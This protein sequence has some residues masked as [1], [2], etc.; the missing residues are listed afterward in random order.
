MKQFK[1]KKYIVAAVV[2]MLAV[3]TYFGAEQA[4][5]ATQRIKS[6]EA[7]YFGE[8]L[9]VG[10]TIDKDDIDVFAT[11]TI[12]DGFDSYEDVEEVRSGFT[13]SPTTVKKEGENKVTV[14]YQGKSAVI[15]VEGKKLEE[16][17]AEYLGDEVY[18]GSPVLKEKIEVIAYFNDGSEKRVKDFTVSGTTVTKT[19]R[20]LYTVTYGK[21]TATIEVYGKEP[22]AV[23]RIEADYTSGKTLYVGDTIPKGDITVTLYYNDGT[24]K[25]AGNTFTISPSVIEHV[26]ENTII[27]SYGGKN[28]KVYIEG[29]EKEVEKLLVEYIGPGVMIGEDVKK[30]E[31]KVT[32][33]YEDKSEVETKEFELHSTK[34]EWEENM[35]FVSCA[36]E[37]EAVFVPGVKGFAG[38]FDNPLSVYMFGNAA[39]TQV[40]LGMNMGLE[41]DKFSIVAADQEIMERVVRRVV[42]TSKFIAFE[43][44]Y[45]DDEMVKEFPMAMKVTVPNGYD[46]EKFGVYYTP[47]QTTIMAKVDG[48]FTDET[49]TEYQFAAYEAGA[50]IIVNEEAQ[51]LVK[52]IIIDDRLKLKVNRNFTLKPQVYPASAE[53]KELTFWTSDA[54]IATVSENGNIKTLKAGVCTILIHASDNGGAFRIITLIVE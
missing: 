7:D 18:V 4:A 27:V 17:T 34:I 12:Y 6:I 46:P 5:A 45:D 44:T 9:E 30:E 38:N 14:T 49:K 43:L 26:G 29:E 32:I 13:I 36:G 48:K 1:W 23:E 52:E 37:T 35:V 25:D 33:V 40:T 39:Y 47:N 2:I 51:A 31:F 16:I 28:D 8:P 20:N 42:P 19:G 22:L 24:E 15:T 50:Y 41:Q 3:C 11:Y 21:F 10:E 53:N 54:S